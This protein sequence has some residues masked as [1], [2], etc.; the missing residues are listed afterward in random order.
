VSGDLKRQCTY[1]PKKKWAELGLNHFSFFERN[2]FFSAETQLPKNLI[3][4]LTQ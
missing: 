4:V 3:V 2:Q 1:T